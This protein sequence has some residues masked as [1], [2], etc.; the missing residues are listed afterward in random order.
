MRCQS[1]SGHGHNVNDTNCEGAFPLYSKPS[2][3]Y[4]GIDS[5]QASKKAQSSQPNRKGAAFI[6]IWTKS[7]RCLKWE[8]SN[9]RQFLGDS[10]C[11]FWG[12]V[13]RQFLTQFLFFAA[14][15][16]AHSDQGVLG[17]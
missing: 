6:P 9:W 14:Q 11:M 2:D 8:L 13:I 17:D 10:C 15:E 5:T 7:Q 16:R 4:E 3:L 1:F 12:K